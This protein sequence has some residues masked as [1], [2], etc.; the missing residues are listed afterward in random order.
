[1]Q[2]C[3]PFWQVAT[4]ENWWMKSGCHYEIALQLRLGAV[5]VAPF[6]ETNNN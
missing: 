5:R 4:G 6:V 3:S 2:P 1:M